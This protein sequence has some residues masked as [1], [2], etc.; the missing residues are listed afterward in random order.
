LSTPTYIHQLQ[1]VEGGNNLIEVDE[2]TFSRFFSLTFDCFR[3]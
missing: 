2:E 3:L 1:L